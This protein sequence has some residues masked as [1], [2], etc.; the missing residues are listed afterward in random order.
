MFTVLLL[1]RLQLPAP[2]PA[3]VPD[4]VQPVEEDPEMVYYFA[5]AE[6]GHIMAV[7]SPETQ[8]QRLQH[9]PLLG[10]TTQMTPGMVVMEMTVMR[11]T[12][13]V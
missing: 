4:P 9:L 13:T 10:E 2:V 11:R 6:D 5:E 3:P 12:M 7:D 8:F 1:S